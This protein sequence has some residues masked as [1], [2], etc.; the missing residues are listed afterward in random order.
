LISRYPAAAQKLARILNV[1]L[2]SE[3]ASLADAPFFA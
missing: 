3:L 1:E 2:R